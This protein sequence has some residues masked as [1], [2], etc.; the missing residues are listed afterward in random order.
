MEG[1]RVWTLWIS[2]QDLLPRKLHELI[3]L[4]KS[5]DKWEAWT[6]L[7]V[8]PELEDSLFEWSP[9]EGYVEKRVPTVY[10]RILQVGD[11]AK[12]FTLMDSEGEPLALSD[13]KG[14]IIWLMF[15]R[16]G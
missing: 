6:N 15:W 2:K 4:A 11:E 14:K 10:E 5:Y 8:D 3:A 13:Y 1:Q 7:R 16:I 9:P 12:D